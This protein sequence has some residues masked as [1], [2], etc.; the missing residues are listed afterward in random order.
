MSG[1]DDGEWESGVAVDIISITPAPSCSSRLAEALCCCFGYRTPHYYD[2]YF[3]LQEEVIIDSESEE[4][5]DDRTQSFQIL[6][7]PAPT[8]R[9]HVI[10][11]LNY[12]DV[13]AI[14]FHGNKDIFHQ[15]YAQFNPINTRRD[16][17][18]ASGDTSTV[19]NVFTFAYILHSI[20]RST[21]MS[22]AFEG[23]E[24]LLEYGEEDSP[25]PW[26]APDSSGD[27]PITLIT[28]HRSSKIADIVKHTN[29]WAAIK[30]LLF[31]LCYNVAVLN[32][33]G[34]VWCKCGPLHWRQ[35]TVQK[36][37]QT[38]TSYKVN[39]LY[40]TWR[41]RN[42]LY[43]FDW[44]AMCSPE[45]PSPD[46]LITPDEIFNLPLTIQTD[47]WLAA[48]TLVGSLLPNPSLHT[49]ID[50]ALM[51]ACLGPANRLH[52][53]PGDL[54]NHLTRLLYLFGE[55]HG[56]TI[57]DEALKAAI[58]SFCENLPSH[59]AASI[60]LK[61]LPSEF[62]D[63]FTGMLSWDPKSRPSILSVLTDTTF[64]TPSEPVDLVTWR[65]V[66][67]KQDGWFG[68]WIPC[69]EWEQSTSPSALYE[70]S[71]LPIACKV[72]HW[73]VAPVWIPSR[74][75]DNPRVVDNVCITR[76]IAVCIVCREKRA[77]SCKENWCSD[78]CRKII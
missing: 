2:E 43:M 15:Q 56:V 69:V 45:L 18:H 41:I 1:V 68:D 53:A 6:Y 29:N 33:I 50:N 7:E 28:H 64:F 9:V 47:V 17:V 62:R 52:I 12:Y 37:P 63:Y 14:S 58:H 11:E 74:L 44:K 46:L 26:G 32:G 5:I 27:N 13:T 40:Y 67:I 22:D 57:A 3:G 39:E 24:A 78:S 70:S 54:Y 23:V 59:P 42:K 21:Y 31:Q 49:F 19:K 25:L 10:D 48:W 77:A 55:P 60:L 36:L 61:Q 34:I 8:T 35:V 65:A 4:I 72:A 73:T 16:A 51:L 75:V 20:V 71:V 66:F 38:T 76:N 30:E